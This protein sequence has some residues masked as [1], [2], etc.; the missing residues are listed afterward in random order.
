MPTNYVTKMSKSGGGTFDVM[1]KGARTLISAEE[2]NRQSADNALEEMVYQ[3][4]NAMKDNCFYVDAEIES[5]SLDS[6]GANTASSTEKRT[7]GYIEVS[8]KDVIL[9][10]GNKTYNYAKVCLY[11]SSKTYLS[12]F[13][14]AEATGSKSVKMLQNAYINCLEENVKY[15]RFAF[16]TYDGSA[17]PLTNDSVKM[18][19]RT[20]SYEELEKVEPLIIEQTLNTLIPTNQTAGYLTRYM[21]FSAT[22]SETVNGLYTDKIPARPGDVFNY[23]GKSAY[24]A[25]GWV[26]LNGNKYVSSGTYN[27]QTNVTVPAN[28][29]HVVFASYEEGTPTL[30][31]KLIEHGGKD[32]IQ[33]YLSGKK[34]GLD[35]DSICWSDS[36]T[37]GYG[38]IL[39]QQYGMVVEN[40][41]ESGATIANETYNVDETERH[42]ICESVP[43]LSTDNDFIIIE[44]GVNDVWQNVPLGEI[45]SGYTATLDKSTFYGAVE[46]VF[47]SLRTKYVNKKVG[48]IIVHKAGASAF[49]SNYPTD[50]TF[51]TAVYNCAKKWGVPVLDLNITVPPFGEMPSTDAT[52][53]EIRNLYTTNGDGTH[54]TQLGYQLFY[55]PKIVSWLAS[56]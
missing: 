52:Y 20:E 40:L 6:Y 5:G 15:V 9:F 56:L 21:A 14:V 24:S 1:D 37:R 34:I 44:G 46:T 13:Y 50:G 28:V 32:D 10:D 8:D 51:Y 55:I 43:N 12:T 7:A 3:F 26:F 16:G 18:M 36:N 29:T 30:E 22:D 54:P 31:V 47:K 33:S 35:G 19:K 48:F 2:T 25:V 41:A 4:Q 11:N 23:K 27:G 49:E 45:T 17:A 38:I 53:N 42:W 39:S